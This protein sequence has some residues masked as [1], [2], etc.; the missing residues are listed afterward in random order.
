M[1]WKEIKEIFYQQADSMST[2]DFNFNWEI[3]RNVKENYDANATFIIEYPKGSPIEENNDDAGG[4]TSRQYRN[5]RIVLFVGRVISDFDNLTDDTSENI[6][7]SANDALDRALE[8][9]KKKFCGEIDPATLCPEGVKKIQYL[10]AV[11][12]DLPSGGAYFP[13]EL[14]VTY[15]I[16]YTENRC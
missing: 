10:N 3:G 4:I 9:I 7:D 13:T 11:H 15:L 12:R 1:G 8:D 14:V 2:P 16:S 6:V 5:D